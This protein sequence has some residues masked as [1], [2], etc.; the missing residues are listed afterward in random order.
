VRSRTRLR[1]LGREPGFDREVVEDTGLQ[2]CGS[3]TWIALVATTLAFSQNGRAPAAPIHSGSPRAESD[4]THPASAPEPLSQEQI[5]SLI[6][7][8]A[9]KDMENDKKQRDYTYR[10]RVEE[11]KLGGKGEIKSTEIR[12]YDVLEIY[13]EQVRR[14]VSKDGKPLPDKDAAKEEEKVQK[15]IDKR[16]NESDSDREKRLKKEEK[17]RAHDR[18]FVKEV[19]DAY[20]FTLTGVENLDGR[21]TYVIDA[22][23]RPGFE[24]HTRETKF[25]PKFRFRLWLDRTEDQWVKLDATSIDTVSIG[26][27]LARIHKGSRILIETTRVNNEV[28]LP[29]H[30]ALHVDARLALLKNIEVDQD[31]TYQDYKKFRT[32]TRI[33]GM[34]EVNDPH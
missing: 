22:E 6:R 8:A 14:L 7:Q 10:E 4:G 13:G 33:V 16:K 29:Q 32:Q 34:E 26:L 15:V 2:R 24:P 23:P 25:L 1:D 18:E 3:L 28:W 17:D 27:F 5:K 11:H 31:V 19:A 20:N 30:V 12:V 9:E 21:E